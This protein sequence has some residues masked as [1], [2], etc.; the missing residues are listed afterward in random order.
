MMK[1]EAIIKPYILDQ[2]REAL[3]SVGVTGMTVYEVKGTSASERPTQVY[4]GAE[5]SLDFTPSVKVEAVVADEMVDKAM[6]AVIQAAKA[7]KGGGG[8]I[9]AFPIGE[10]VR[11]RTGEH[12][13]KAL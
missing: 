2:V 7:A 12:G 3:T 9:F 6:N 8:K 1:I 4:R 10:A 13:V 5:Y 11:I